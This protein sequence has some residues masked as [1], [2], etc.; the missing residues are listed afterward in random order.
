MYNAVFWPT[1]E[2]PIEDTAKDKHRSLYNCKGQSRNTVVKVTGPKG[3]LYSEV[4][5][6]MYRDLKLI[7][8][9]TS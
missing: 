4:S 7:N 6:V 8:L 9:Y 3:V 1:V 5:H 2:P